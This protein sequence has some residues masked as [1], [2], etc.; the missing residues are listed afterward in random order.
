M[1]L[2]IGD[3]IL[4]TAGKD[5]GR[6]GK[7][8]KVFPKKNTVLVP[9]ANVYKKHRKPFPALNIEG[10]IIEFSRPLPIGNVQLVCPECK[11]I[12]RV[13]YEVLKNGGK[14]RICRKCGKEIDTKNHKA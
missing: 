12:T 8:G 10:G 13:G 7:I 3:E 6:H 1:K 9:E 14:I 5:K 4:I 2:K 11:K